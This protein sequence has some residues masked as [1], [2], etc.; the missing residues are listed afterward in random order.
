MKALFL[1]A[2]ALLGAAAATPAM[3]A[4]VQ[5][6]VT[7]G[8]Q[9]G[10]SGFPATVTYT[11]TV[12]ASGSITDVIFTMGRFSMS[13]LADGA[14]ISLT[15]NGKT[16]VLLD[17][18]KCT[19]IYNTIYIGNQY[20]KYDSLPRSNCNSAPSAFMPY[21]SMKTAFAGMEMKGDW[22]ITFTDVAGRVNG[23]SGGTV[24][25]AS[26]YVTYD[27]PIWKYGAY[28]APTSTCGP[29]TKTRT[30][31]CTV[32]GATVDDS[33][34]SAVAK[35]ETTVSSNETSGCTYAWKTGDWTSVYGPNSTCGATTEKTTV[36]CER[37]DPA[38]TTVADTF[39]KAGTKP[40][41][42]RPYTDPVQCVYGWD[43][44]GWYDASP[45]T[46]GSSTRTRIV[47]CI[48]QTDPGFSQAESLCAAQ[49]KPETTEAVSNYDSCMYGWYR[50]GY[51]LSGCVGGQQTYR[52]YYSCYRSTGATA[53][54][55][56]GDKPPSRVVTAQCGYWADH[57]NDG[58]NDTYPGMTPATG[59]YTTT[60]VKVGSGAVSSGADGVRGTIGTVATGGSG[61]SVTPRPGGSY[62]AARDVYTGTDGKSYTGGY[63]D[64]GAYYG[65]TER[66]PDPVATPTPGAT[67][68]PTPT[69]TPDS[70]TG[71]T[72]P[73][74]APAGTTIIMRRPV[75]RH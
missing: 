67:P 48:S 27:T 25:N 43:V 44:G 32:A 15:H 30:A 9:F 59:Y 36:T 3:A 70:G 38:K 22:I 46:C 49:P 39:C 14:R 65:G 68:A 41:D 52:A 71:P 55:F 18:S 16:V 28:S 23:S 61:S 2:T 20:Q 1:A 50:S 11:V 7:P 64:G 56:C 29:A 74:T 58:W 31:T 60:G 63:Y 53:S 62:D 45:T 33:R 75:P 54:G 24:S 47:R 4:Q 69:P 12:E 21:E 5:S 66:A 13:T 72:D 34:C 35:E 73:G 51:E 42:T 17:P 8:G 6:T 19:N 10:R 57:L 37:S 26:I 40:T